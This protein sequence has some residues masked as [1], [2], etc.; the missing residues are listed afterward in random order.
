MYLVYPRVLIS[1]IDV[2]GGLWGPSAS[3][4]C[5]KSR[6]HVYVNKTNKKTV[7]SRDNKHPKVD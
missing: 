6:F 2:I 7:L 3:F 4:L 1:K 5:F